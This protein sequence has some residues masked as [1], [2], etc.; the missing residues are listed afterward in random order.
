MRQDPKDSTKDSMLHRVVVAMTKLDLQPGR[1]RSSVLVDAP[2]FESVEE[3]LR[4]A[5]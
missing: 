2:S 1:E 5:N 4:L 3:L